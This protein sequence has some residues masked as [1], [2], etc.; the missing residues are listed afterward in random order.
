MNTSP[1]V[2]AVV[3]AIALLQAM[4]RQA[5]S[6]IDMLYVQTGIPKPT[7]VRLLRTLESQQL[8]RRAPQHGAYYLTSGVR[9]LSAGYHSEPKIV[10]AAM[11]LMDAMTL[12]VKWPMAI[13]VFDDSAVVVR[14][15]TIPI[16]PLALLH[17]SINMRLSMVS[18]ALGRAYLAFCQKTE[19]ELILDTLAVS[20]D[21]EDAPARDQI[22]MRKLLDNI[23]QA[24]YATRS[25]VVRP[26][27]R[28]LAV[29]VMV[30]ER[31]VATVGLTFFASVLTESKA[32][33]TY[34]TDLQQLARNIGTRLQEL[35]EPE[36]LAGPDPTGMPT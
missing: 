36:A 23:R 28:T 7:I 8:V 14:Y 16:S 3:R 27:S 31:V 21:P 29:P 35:D 18:R 12:K 32:V 4:N 19:Q 2:R 13:A 11:S 17:S 1:P 24:G 20:T 33:T 22:A 34:L 9:S 10:E 25:P 15:S 30:G 26:I 5:V 6:T